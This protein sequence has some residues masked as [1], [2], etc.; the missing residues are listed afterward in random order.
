MFFQHI[1]FEFVLPFFLF[2]L[3]IFSLLRKSQIFKDYTIE[4]GIS[5]IISFLGSYWLYINKLSSIIISSSGIIIFIIFVLVILISIALKGYKKI[6][7]SY[8]EMKKE[9]ND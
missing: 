5:I 3:I 2:F 7:K 8:E 4:F 9:K 1:I 6:E